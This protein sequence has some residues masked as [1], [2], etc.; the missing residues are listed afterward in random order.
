MSTRHCV[1]LVATSLVSFSWL[2]FRVIA[3]EPPNLPTLKPGDKA[4]VLFVA[5]APGAEKNV[6][7]KPAF[8][9]LDPVVFLI[10]G[11]L[12]DCATAHPAPGQENIPKA[13]L[14]TLNRIYSSG[15]RYPL[16]SGGAP[17]GDAEAVHS[18]IE[19]SDGDYL[20]FNGC[21]RLHPDNAHHAPPN[22]FKGTV[23]TGSPVTAS[24]TAL[25][26]K[27]TSDERTI[28][29]Q[30]ASAVFAAR[31]VRIAPSS[32]HTGSIWKTQLQASHIALAGSA[33]V[34]LASIKPK[35]Y[36]SYRLFL[37]V[38]ENGST[39]LPVLNHYHKST[40]ALDNTSPPKVGEVLDEEENVDKEVF[41]DNFPLFP[42]EPDAVITEHSYYE[43]WAYSI[44]RRIGATYQLLYTGCGGGT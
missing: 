2:S 20:D 28:F 23:W 39:Y 19:G 14:Q 4:E 8:A 12:R 41:V 42:G 34:Q 16:W 25:R 24:H 35:T 9:S 17:W 36:Y 10:G 44:Y 30:A 31:H 13:T 22:D 37:V 43:S 32:I 1:L 29:L 7:G 21:F 33:L 40:I 6:T 15:R 11:E 38:E 5:S 18:C 27:A 26:T 3:Q